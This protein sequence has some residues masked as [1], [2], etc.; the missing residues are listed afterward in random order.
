METYRQPI[1]QHPL[2]ELAR[3]KLAEHRPKQDRAAP[4]QL[5]L[6]EDRAGPCVV[7]TILYDKLHLILGAHP[8]KILPVHSLDH[9]AT[10]AFDVQDDVS[11][12]VDGGNINRSARL[13]QDIVALRT[14]SFD[15]RKCAWLMEW[16]AARDLGQ[17]TVIVLDGSEDLVECHHGPPF[18]GIFAV[19]PRAAQGAARQSNKHA[20]SAGVA[21]FAL[22]AVEDLSHSQHC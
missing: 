1:L 13:D 9:A 15:Q 8:G 21:G 18:K 3:L 20:R 10:R 2:R 4:C 16:L 17:G 12:P 14:E 22:N 7:S 11:S 19:A 5:V 6:R